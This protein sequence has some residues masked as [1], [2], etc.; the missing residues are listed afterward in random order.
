[1]ND[2]GVLQE[3]IENLNSQLKVLD[4]RADHLSNY[5]SSIENHNITEISSKYNEAGNLLLHLK[6]D[7]IRRLEKKLERDMESMDQRIE[8]LLMQIKAKHEHSLR[9]V[10]KKTSQDALIECEIQE[11]F[12]ISVCR[13]MN[14]SSIGK[15]SRSKSRMNKRENR[16]PNVDDVDFDDEID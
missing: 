1:M 5:L 2:V 16:E 9:S 13:K 10:D 11:I 14:S 6:H 3:E 7:S 8:T 12:E 15:A 4:I